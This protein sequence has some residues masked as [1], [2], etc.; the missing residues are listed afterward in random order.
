[1]SGDLTTEPKVKAVRNGPKVSHDLNSMK[2]FNEDLNTLEIFAFAHDEVEK[3]SGQ[4][5]FDTASRLS[6]TLKRRYLDYLNKKELDLHRPGF[7]SLRDFDVNEFKT[8][9]SDYTR[10]FFGSDVKEVKTLRSKN[11]NV[12]Q[13]TVDTESN[14]KSMTKESSLGTG[15]DIEKKTN[16]TNEKSSDYK[17]L[18]EKS[19]SCCFVCARSEVKHFLGKCEKFK[20]YLKINARSCLM[21]GDV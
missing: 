10:S 12:R 11:Y 7:D 18:K 3:L 17:R 13:V 14:S 21:L 6:N 9:S 8:M 4:L 19:P 20:T 2:I 5:L 16:S 1:M 15:Q